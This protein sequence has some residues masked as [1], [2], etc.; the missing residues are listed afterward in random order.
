MPITLRH[1]FS[2]MMPPTCS[3]KCLSDHLCGIRATFVWMFLTECCSTHKIENVRHIGTPW[4]GTWHPP[5]LTSALDFLICTVSI[6]SK[7]WIC[8]RPLYRLSYA[9]R[10]FRKFSIFL[11]DVRRQICLV[12][13]ACKSHYFPLCAMLWGF[14]ATFWDVLFIIFK[15]LHFH[16]CITYNL[17]VSLFVMLQNAS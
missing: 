3:I 16:V 15:L 8:V 4:L 11:D 5:S 13:H 10:L 17:H 12:A 7:F 2:K 9:R 14:W 6:W 1:I